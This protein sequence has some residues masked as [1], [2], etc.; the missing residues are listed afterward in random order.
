[1]Y[2]RAYK[3]YM[4]WFLVPLA[5]V[6]IAYFALTQ[7][8]KMLLLPVAVP[9]MVAIINKPKLW[10]YIFLLASVQFLGIINPETF[11][12]LPGVLKF[13]DLLFLILVT[14]YL[15]DSL[16]NG[17]YYPVHNKAA[18]WVAFTVLT[19][20]SMVIIQFVITAL[21]F[22]LPI[23]STIKV[24]R[25]YLYLLV[26]FYFVRFYSDNKSMQQLL[27]L[28]VFVCIVQFSLM[29][30]QMLGINLTANTKIIDLTTDAGSVTRVYLP[31][32]F[33]ALMCFF[34]S[35]TLLLSNSLPSRKSFILTV[36]VISFLS[37]LL[38][39][40]R[41][42]W[43]AILLGMLIIFLFSKF[44]VKKR[45]F[46][47]SVITFVFVI[48]IL[49]LK[50]GTFFVERFSSIFTE[51]RSSDEGNFIYRFSENPKRLEAFFD[52]PIFGPGFVH[53]NYAASLFNFVIDETGLSEAQIERALLLQ[54]NDSGLITL[55]VSF[56]LCGVLWVLFKMYILIK[57]YKEQRFN[58]HTIHIKNSI[59]MQ[60][61]MLAFICSVWLTC[62]T[63]YGFTYPD[64]VVAL[65]LSLFVFSF[66]Q[67]SNSRIHNK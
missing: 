29:L 21:R 24:G 59:N 58:L 54:T 8:T 38:S 63:T 22:D 48:P 26:Y 4:L 57:L 25:G 13:N 44:E 31:A 30:F 65:A 50:A 40:T 43:L 66:Y 19:F 11:I 56:G 23:V 20:V 41:T 35:V 49:L 9:I 55:L 45:I 60:L 47:Y 67:V 53:E 42:Y 33:F 1:M 16:K 62:V 32:Y 3:K 28:I 14:L 64:G 46:K 5:V 18:K 12:R 17:F 37:I 10:G 27:Y 52:N 39:Y 36:M 6:Y 2:N 51:V 61:G 15:L 34:C 7:N